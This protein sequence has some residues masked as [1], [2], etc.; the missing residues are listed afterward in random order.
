MIE[1]LTAMNTIM[2][3]YLI[4]AQL[5][6]MHRHNKHQLWHKTKAS[7]EDPDNFKSAI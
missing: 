5:W 3:G 4:L 7:A 1:I 2:I 6:S